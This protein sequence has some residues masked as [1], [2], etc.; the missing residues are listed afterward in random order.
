LLG[1]IRKKAARRAGFGVLTPLGTRRSLDLTTLR[2]DA[3]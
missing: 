3:N 2:K 1:R